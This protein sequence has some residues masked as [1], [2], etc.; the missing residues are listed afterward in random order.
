MSIV[1]GVDCSTTTVAFCVLDSIQ[2]T[3][4]F[5]V[6]QPKGT[7]WQKIDELS[8]FVKAMDINPEKI[9]IETAL[10]RFMPGFSSIQ[11]IILL[12]RFNISCQILM[13]DKFKIDPIEI[14]AATARKACKVKL[15]PKKKDPQGRDHK[16]QTFD[17]MMASDLKHITWPLKKNSRK[18]TI[19]TGPEAISYDKVDAYVIARAGLNLKL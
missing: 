18:P 17:A 16:T 15:V 7:F 2:N 11:T 1:L 12:Q 9:F 4:Q 14:G 3:E 8:T 10:E 6:L 13:R 5:F 19:H